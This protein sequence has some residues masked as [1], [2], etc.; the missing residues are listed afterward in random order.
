[1]NPRPPD[2]VWIV[3]LALLDA[4]L[5]LTLLLWPEPDPLCHSRTSTGPGE[6]GGKEEGTWTAVITA[7][8]L[9][10]ADLVCIPHTLIRER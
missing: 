3:S 5:V 1:L 4:A 2:Q 7:F 8:G 9:H 10:V 6:P